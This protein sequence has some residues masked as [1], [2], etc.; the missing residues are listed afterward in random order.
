MDNVK[1]LMNRYNKAQLASLE[2]T[3]LR[4]QLI[5][6]LK[7]EGLTKTKFDFGDRVIKYHNYTDHEGITQALIKNVIRQ[8]YPQI[9]PDQF[10]KDLY[11]ARSKKRIE[12]IRVVSKTDT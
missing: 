1:D 11:G 7:N 9:D 10:V 5:P 4:K 6:L 12:T 3:R 8:K 2:A